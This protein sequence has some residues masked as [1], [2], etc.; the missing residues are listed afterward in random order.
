M[1]EALQDI[2]TWYGKSNYTTFKQKN[3]LNFFQFSMVI[4][5]MFIVFEKILF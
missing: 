1:H 5:K 4:E 2:L 3:I